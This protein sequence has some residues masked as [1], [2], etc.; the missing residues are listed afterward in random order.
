LTLSKTARKVRK[1]RA[2]KLGSAPFS[3]APNKKATVA[4]KLT[5]A[6]LKAVNKKGRLNATATATLTGAGSSSQK[7]RLAATR[8]KKSA[9]RR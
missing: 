5:R 9:R 6:G 2:A 4:V 7:L 8:S 3:I 1:S